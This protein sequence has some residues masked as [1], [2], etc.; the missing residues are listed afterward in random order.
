MSM[1]QVEWRSASDPPQVATGE[2]VPVIVARK[3]DRG[4]WCVFGAVYLNHVEIEDDYSD[5]SFVMIGFACDYKHDDYDVYYEPIDVLF[6]APM[7]SPP[8]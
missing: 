4:R 8:G 5:D 7:P 6:W 3:S 1:T 2:S